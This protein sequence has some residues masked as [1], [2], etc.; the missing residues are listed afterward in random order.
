RTPRASAGPPGRTASPRRC[1]DGRRR[2]ASFGAR[3]S[4]PHF[5]LAITATILRR[6]RGRPCVAPSAAMRGAVVGDPDDP[7]GRAIRCVA[8]LFAYIDDSRRSGT[9]ITNGVNSLVSTNVS[10]GD[11]ANSVWTESAHAPGKSSTPRWS[12][13]SRTHL[14]GREEP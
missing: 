5:D 1:P 7:P 11:G 12:P 2:S 8:A 3:E 10:T 14:D 6:S 4:S 13:G 9:A